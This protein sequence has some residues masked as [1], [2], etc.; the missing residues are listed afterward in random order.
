MLLC[1]PVIAN[2]GGHIHGMNIHLTGREK[3]PVL[4]QATVH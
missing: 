1:L 4:H 3:R 2:Y